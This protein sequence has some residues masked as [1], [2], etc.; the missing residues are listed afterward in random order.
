MTVNHTY[1]TL[2]D[3][4]DENVNRDDYFTTIYNAFFS[5][6]NVPYTH[7]IPEEIVLNAPYY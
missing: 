2:E 3:Y 7:S 4:G 1:N 5:D 6:H